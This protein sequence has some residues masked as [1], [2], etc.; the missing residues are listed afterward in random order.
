MVSV[1][2]VGPSEVLVMPLPGGDETDDAGMD[3]LLLA[4][5]GTVVLDAVDEVG[6]TLDSG[7]A[8]GGGGAVPLAAGGGMGVLLD[9]G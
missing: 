3:S 7:C 2:G 5:V 1:G 6:V 9:N 8:R 4:A